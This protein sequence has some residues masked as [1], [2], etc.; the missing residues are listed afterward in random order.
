MSDERFAKAAEDLLDLSMA[1]RWVSAMEIGQGKKATVEI[2]LD[3]E[4]VCNFEFA[5]FAQDLSTVCMKLAQDADKRREQE[6]YD[7]EFDD[8]VS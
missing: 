1:L 5:P 8:P 4:N 3:G 2:K 6:A 7:D